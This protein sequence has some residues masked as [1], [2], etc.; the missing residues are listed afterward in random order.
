M[1]HMILLN[2]FIGVSHAL[3]FALFRERSMFVVSND[4]C[5]LD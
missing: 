4:R 5:L 3:H 2:L 1:S